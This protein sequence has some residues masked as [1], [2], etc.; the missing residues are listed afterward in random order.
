[1][2]ETAT[3]LGEGLAMALAA[4]NPRQVIIAS[5]SGMGG[6]FFSEMVY[7]VIKESVTPALLENFSVK[8]VKAQENIGAV[9][10]AMM[11]MEDEYQVAQ[12]EV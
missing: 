11:M 12:E 4:I 10:A 9:G 1:M 5:K 6:A 3:Y 2:K 7:D 8:C